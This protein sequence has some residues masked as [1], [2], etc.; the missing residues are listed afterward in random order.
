[1][2]INDPSSIVIIRGESLAENIAKLGRFSL[3]SFKRQFRRRASAGVDNT[4]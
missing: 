1:M 3:L 2:L 4:V